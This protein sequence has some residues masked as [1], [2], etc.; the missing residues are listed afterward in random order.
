MT[1]KK[2]ET[3]A[4]KMVLLRFRPKQYHLILFRPFLEAVKI[5]YGYL[6]NL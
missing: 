5:R 4:Q 1:G 2:V 6:L 3:E